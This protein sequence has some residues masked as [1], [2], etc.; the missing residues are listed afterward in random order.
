MSLKIGWFSTARDAAARNLLK[1]VRDDIIANDVPARLEWI[2]CHRET[3]DGP[4]N[5]EY[6]QREMFFDMA[7]EFDIPVATLSHV[8]FMPELRK[9]GI[10]KSPSAAQASEELERWRNLYGEQVVKTI[11]ILPEVDVI[12]MAG[13]KIGRAH[14]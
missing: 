11:R 10:Q 14:V 13:Y 2:F 12:V 1:A 7:A 4:A 6:I 3:G 8:R 5:E 9:L